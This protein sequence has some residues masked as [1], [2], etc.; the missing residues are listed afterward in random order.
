MKIGPNRLLGAP[1]KRLEDPRILF[2]RG[3]YVA[4]IKLH[5]MVHAAFLRSSHA[6]A[7][8]RKLDVS[9]CRADPRVLHVLTAADLDTV[10]R[11]PSFD[12]GPEVAPFLQPVLAV[13]TVR[14]VGEPMAAVV[15]ADRY[16]AEDVLELIDV[17]YDVL[18][19]V[20]DPE[21]ALED[22][23]PLLHGTSNIID[24]TRYLVGEPGAVDRTPH[25]IAGRYK[26]E[27]DA[28]MPI[29]TRGSVAEWDLGRGTLSVHTSTQLPHI[30][31]NVLADF[32]GLP[33]SSVRVVAP[34]V[35][36]AFGAKL[37]VYPEDF[38]VSLLAR[39]LDR[40]VKWIEDRWE[41]FVATTH[42]REQTINIEVG[43]D[44]EGLILALRTNILTNTGAYAQAF[45]KSE[46]S[47]AAML[48]RGAYRI[49]NFEATSTIVASN[50][51]PMGPYRG[52]GMVQPLLALERTLDLIGRERGIDPVEIRLRNM[53]TPDD[54]PY[55]LEVGNPLNGDFIYDS[56]DYP[57]ALLHALELAGYQE[58]RAQQERL[59]RE[60]H[61]VGIGIAPYTEVTTIGPYE[62]STVRV[63]P[64]GQ[65]VVLS[66]AGPSGQ[67]TQTT[68]AQVAADEFDVP[69]E[70]VVVLHGDTEIVRY[71]VGSFSSRIAA[72]GST[73]VTLAS[74]RVKDKLFITAAAMLEVSAEDLQLQDGKVVVKGAP[75]RG[76]TL[77]EIA[78][79]LEPGRPLPPGVE[80]YGLEWTEMFH[81]AAN[82]FAYGTVVAVVDVDIET[83]TIR[84]LRLVMVG[85]SGTII[86]PLLVD[87]QY[88][89][90]LVMGL[91]EALLEQIVYGDDGQPLN[92]NFLDY[93]LPQ[94]DN[95]PEIVLGHTSV[96]TPHNPLG[97]KGAG[98]SGAIAPPAALANAISDALSLFGVNITAI[99]ILPDQLYRLLKSARGLAD[100]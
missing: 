15:A 66:G 2:G 67:G 64:S 19:A 55:R 80:S 8:V 11:L 17:E 79:A 42:G 26:V 87:G 47:L 98:E 76:A 58:F 16:V 45:M 32:F 71:G 3:R 28:G 96:P 31:R 33:G 30:V 37:Q 65:I 20:I 38:V 57:R 52:V 53:L 97:I 7:R 34:D 48:A 86:N 35:G 12:S 18:P 89:G 49:E 6:Y 25:V 74:A 56:G 21:Q 59:R 69:V 36:G 54:M 14:Y 82:A 4:D 60:G 61:Y 92:P 78:S 70:D 41:H 99:P 100:A 77:G 75:D 29:E 62:S 91:G 85:D 94:V 50:K 95:V 27:R 51:T 83:C 10:P 13:D 46:P 9:R 90:G 84:P 1:V 44:D 39:R 23:A 72:L 22:G 24:I 5:G 40:P 93:R 68:L 63:D 43:Y 73:A 88:Q 81:P